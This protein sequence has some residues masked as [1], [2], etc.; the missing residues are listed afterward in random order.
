MHVPSFFCDLACLLNIDLYSAEDTE[1]KTKLG[2]QKKLKRKI[3][4]ND[5]IVDSRPAKKANTTGLF[6]NTGRPKRKANTGSICNFLPLLQ[7]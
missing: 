5:R 4:D 1:G 7:W 6:V 2:D 3:G